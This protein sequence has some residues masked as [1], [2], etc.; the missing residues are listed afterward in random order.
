[1]NKWKQYIQDLLGGSQM[2]VSY[3]KKEIK[4]ETNQVEEMSKENE[5]P[6]IKILRMQ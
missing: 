5:Y 6:T 4:Q 1:M 3:T 2:E